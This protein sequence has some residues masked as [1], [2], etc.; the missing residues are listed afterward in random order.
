MEDNKC[1]WQFK[2]ESNV[3]DQVASL[4]VDS[5]FS[6]DDW[7]KFAREIIQN[8]LDAHDN[9]LN[10]CQPVLVK[11]SK[12][13]LPLKSI[14]GGE[15]LKEIIE[16]AIEYVKKENNRSSTLREYE[17]GLKMLSQET[18]PC[19]KISDYNTIGMGGGT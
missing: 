7:V 16:S 2:E 17:Q 11:F 14:P 4:F 8:S 5:T 12:E 18:I 6:D 13:F 15:R 1:D 3:S 9:D 10:P 19:L